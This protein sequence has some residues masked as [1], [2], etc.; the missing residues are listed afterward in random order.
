MP[1]EHLH[2]SGKKIALSLCLFFFLL[3]T[4]WAQ[5][6]YK[7]TYRFICGPAQVTLTNTCTML[8]EYEPFCSR[9][10]LEFFNTKTGK[11]L[12]QMY[13]PKPFQDFTQAFM[14]ELTCLKSR[15]TYYIKAGNANY[16]NCSTCEWEDIFDEHGKYIGSS[17]RGITHALS[18]SFRPLP[19]DFFDVFDNKKIIDSIDVFRTLHE[20]KKP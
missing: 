11:K 5:K 16:A 18:R 9:Q 14:A 6:D 2:P 13:L 8:D 3:P 19:R 10:K 15:G 7:T 20:G 4:A 17:R 12:E 1:R